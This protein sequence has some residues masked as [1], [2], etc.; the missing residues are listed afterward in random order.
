MRDGSPQ[1]GPMI[2]PGDHSIDSRRVSVIG[3]QLLSGLWRLRGGTGAL[4]PRA[5]GL[6]MGPLARFLEASWEGCDQS[7][8]V[9]SGSVVNRSPTRP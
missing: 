8:S 2:R 5:S 4:P 6:S 1:T 9:S 3:A 7:F